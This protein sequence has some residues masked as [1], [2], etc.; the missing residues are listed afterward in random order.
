MTDSDKTM[1]IRLMTVRPHLYQI[2]DSE[3]ILCIRWLTV[4][5]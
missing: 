3:K 5:A 1:F 4:S 2:T